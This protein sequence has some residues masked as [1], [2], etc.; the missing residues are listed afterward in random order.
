LSRRP[1]TGQSREVRKANGEILRLRA[2]IRGAVQGVG[3]RPFVYGLAKELGLSGWVMNTG[4]GV[5][6]EVDG[7]ER[8][9]RQFLLRIEP[10]APAH[11]VIHGLEASWLD[12]AGFAGFEIRSS[13]LAGPKTALVLPDIATCGPC[14]RE[15]LDPADRRFGYPFTNCTHCGPRYSIIEALPYDRGRTSM[16]GFP[17][18][19]ACRAEYENPENR[20]FHA[21]PNACPDCGPQ[22]ELW[23]EAGE[24]LAGRGE[25]LQAAVAALRDGRVVAVKGLGGFHLMVRADDEGAVR[26]LRERKRR[27]EKPF[28]LLLPSIAMAREVCEVSEMEARLL[29]SPEAP[30]VLMPRRQGPAGI[31]QAV[32]PGIAQLGV[33]LPSN[34]LHHLMMRELGTPVVATS[35]NLS[36]EPICTGNE[37]ALDRLGGIADLFLVHDRPIVRHVDDSIARVLLGREMVLRR[38]R[39]YAPMPVPLPD[40]GLAPDAPPVLAVGAHLKNTVAVASAGRVIVSQHLGDLETE[41]ACRAHERAARDL[42]RLFEVAPRRVACDQH[43]DYASTRYAESTGL[44]VTR[45]QHHHAHAMACM[46]ENGIAP[47]ALAAVWDGTGYGTDGTIWG[48]EFLEISAGGFRRAA[49]LRTFPLPG[50]DAA[51]RE[52]RRAMAG[53]LWEM[54]RFEELGDRFAAHERRLLERMFARGVNTVPTSSAGRLID[55]VA[56]LLGLRQVAHY[57]AQ[58]AMELESAAAA[59]GEAAGFTVSVVGRE[60]PWSVDWAPWI[61]AMTT[62]LAAGEGPGP[63]AARF[64]RALVGALVEVARRAECGQVVLSGG[65]FQNRI[66]LEGAVRELRKAGFR[67]F[68]HQRIPPNDGGVSCGQAVAAQ[69]PGPVRGGCEGGR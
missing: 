36:D 41:A 5:V 14:L 1:W 39:G 61:E 26:R 7:D 22:L 63:L 67:P 44:H 66:L 46:A 50:G 49:H 51:A 45:V 8:R 38:A 33:M 23:S 19:A 30:I 2:V 34:P 15:I 25:A 56:S 35:G 55:G 31:V 59:A 3:F 68:W 43:P 6:V 57:E 4:E 10:G 52:P 42:Q 17:M 37:E 65:C 28:A 29:E 40:G 12:A 21:Q 11:A 24:V 47:P 9:L 53:M 60:R 13:P 27:E 54:G 69:L 58:A 62:G 20:R 64:H 16:K 32:A 48:G 18:C